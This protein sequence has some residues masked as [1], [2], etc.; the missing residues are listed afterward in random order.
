MPQMSGGNSQAIRIGNRMSPL[1][2]KPQESFAGESD[3]FFFRRTIART[4]EKFHINSIGMPNGNG[5]LQPAKLHAPHTSER[6]WTCI[7]QACLLSHDPMLTRERDAA[8]A[9][10]SRR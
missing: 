1:V 5:R 3:D 7:E 2:S 4:D 6:I 8:Q 9:L 10:F